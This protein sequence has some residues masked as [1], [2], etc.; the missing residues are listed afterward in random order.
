MT[1]PHDIVIHLDE[2]DV[3]RDFTLMANLA[4]ERG[5]DVTLHLSP[6][7]LARAADVLGLIVRPFV[8]RQ[9]FV[10]LVHGPM[11]PP[12]LAA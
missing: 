1:S 8:E 7:F 11:P 6:G 4:Y 3:S 2:S 5:R 10:R 9:V 12:A